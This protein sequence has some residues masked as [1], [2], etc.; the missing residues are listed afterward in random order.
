MKKAVTIKDIAQQLN[1]SR[2]TVAK[3]LNGQYVPERTRELV[4]K[5]AQ[6]MKYKSLN[7]SHIEVGGKKWRI[8]LI[9]GKPLNNINYFIPIIRGIENYCYERHYELFQYT[10]DS[11]R[12][13]F[14]G[15]AD[16]AKELNVD[17]IVAIECFDK[18]FISKLINLG[19][20]VCFNDFS[21]SDFFCS[22]S[23]D[24]ITTNGLQ[25]VYSLV[26]SL[27]KAYKISR[28][29]FVGDR[30]HCLSFNDRYNGMVR[31]LASL[32]LAHSAEEDILCSDE[33]F[34][35]GSP[36]AL[37]TEILKLRYRPECFICSNDF[38][39]RGV[40][41]ALKSLGMSVPE[42][43]FVAGFDNVA[44]AV[45]LTPAITTFAVDKEF[46]GRE[47]I[48]TLVNRIE[49]PSAPSRTITVA[50]TLIARASTQR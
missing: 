49:T 42:N 37:K 22:E 10:Y 8:L 15:F 7:L 3:A 1:M 18:A 4:L 29:T 38:I 46:L 34:D 50:A 30:K 26:R 9:S 39:A 14:K 36:A 43:A 20:P 5:K 31:A 23:F 47:T 32:K 2:N 24:I 25:S 6:E 48:R 17:G 16:Y 19:T 27:H 33:V 28:F 12:T 21:T 13:P 11:M 41:N 40:C 35:Y 44:E 45:S